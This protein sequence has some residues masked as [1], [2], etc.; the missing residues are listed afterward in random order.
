MHSK[1]DA[2][3]CGLVYYEG[4]GRNIH[5]AKKETPLPLPFQFCLGY[6]QVWRRSNKN[7]LEKVGIP[8]YA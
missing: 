5:K 4:Y 7:D 6:L 2:L 8:F 1:S 3:F